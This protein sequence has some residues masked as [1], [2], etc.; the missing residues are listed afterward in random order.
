[1]LELLPG[2]L[3]AVS[4]VLGSGVLF[5]RWGGTGG[6][7]PF[8]WAGLRGL[9]GIA[10]LATAGGFINIFLPLAVVAPWVMFPLAG[11]GVWV[12]MKQA[13]GA[14]RLVLLCLVLAAASLAARSPLH[15]DTGLYH[16]QAVIWMSE[17]ALPYGLANLHGRFGFNS[18]WWNF[19]A[20]L[21]MPWMARGASMYLATPV[22]CVFFGLLFAGALRRAWNSGLT[23][24]VVMILAAGYLW[25][26][27][28]SGA[29]NPSLSTDA[30]VNLFIVASAVAL[31]L[32][33]SER[34]PQL[35]LVWSILACAAAAFK[36]TGLPWLVASGAVVGWSLVVPSSGSRRT[37]VSRRELFAMLAGFVVL[38]VNFVRGIVVSGYPFYP[39][40]LF[41]FGGL[42]WS[43]RPD[44]I[45]GDTAGIRNWP[46]RGEAAHWLEFIANW[47]ENQ[48]GLTNVVM[49]LVL[50]LA[51]AALLF[52][53]GRRNFRAARALLADNL[54]VVLAAAAGLAVCLVYAP[55]LR[56]VSGYFFTL[57]G[58]LLGSGLIALPS[59]HSIRMGR[60][61]VVV[62]IILAVLP[63][64]GG[65]TG[66]AIAWR[67]TPPAPEADRSLEV[68]TTR[69][70]ESI[71]IG[72]A[73]D[74]EPPATP[75]F[76]PDLVVVRDKTGAIREFRVAHE[77]PE[78]P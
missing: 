77:K 17:S 21:Q 14:F 76:E 28:M 6:L 50:A 5:A 35:L 1:M 30:P 61:A 37:P 9:V 23:V 51:I 49:A 67:Q 68:R 25:F 73:W 33:R 56:F 75:Y 36:L 48:Y 40:T 29:N 10:L 45:G 46:T 39:L 7:D 42:P 53:V 13:S 57:A 59:S 34:S 52:V 15:G 20:L 60:R 44:T 19:A 78:S 18:A 74:A 2:L 58:L 24:A 71:K 65:L 12:L 54:P 31:V 62:A 63:N 3:L 43:V 4:A 27:Q 26:R 64:A 41:G 55:A 8:M 72:F 47:I 69:Q 32:W 38:S 66:R 22:L 16:Q 11:L 70:G